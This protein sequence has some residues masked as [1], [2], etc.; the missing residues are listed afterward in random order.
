MDK[1]TVIIP[2]YNVEAYILE[3][4]ESVVLQ[5]DIVHHTYVV[6]NNSTDDTVGKVREWKNDHPNVPLT[7]LSETNPGA[8]AAR[9]FPLARVE[10]KWIQFLDADDLLLPRKI[11]EQILQFPEADVICAASQH[12]TIE[13]ER[14]LSAP[15]TTIPIGLME[16]EAGNTCANL[17][18]LR[19]IESVNGWDESLKSSQEY[20]LMFRIWQTGASFE[21]DL[22]PRALI[23]ERP[24]GQISQG[25]LAENWTRL[26]QLRERMLTAFI[27]NSAMNDHQKSELCQSFF[28]KLRILAKHDLSAALNHFHRV[29]K[30]ISFT[31]RPS[32]TTTATYILLFRILGFDGAE[33]IKRALRM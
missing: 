32:E 9:N 28:D 2:C 23:R 14:R 24:S 18:S 26:I 21:V 15:R 12:L 16:G 8:P 29:L 7:L 3:C 25:N 30:P 31:P 5:G 20:D 10:T 19:S 4:L 27:E 33:R 11:S 17:F 22:T 1:A 6:D 13:G